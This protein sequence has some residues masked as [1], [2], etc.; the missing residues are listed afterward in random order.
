MIQ[1]ILLAACPLPK[2]IL[3][4]NKYARYTRYGETFTMQRFAMTL[5]LKPEAEAEYRR[6]HAAVW[7]DVLQTIHSCDIRN[8]SIFLHDGVLF[9]YLEYV[10]NDF[11]LDMQKM[12]DDPKTQ[13]WCAITK[14]MQEALETHKPGAWRVRMDAW[15][16]AAFLNVAERIGKVGP[17]RC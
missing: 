17:H 11:D 12:A 3:H 2:N 6:L 14:P 13:Q 10:E 5:L 16:A 4:V 7:P 9:G 8:Y 1:P 15:N